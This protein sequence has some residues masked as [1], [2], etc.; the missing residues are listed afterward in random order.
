[1][2]KIPYGISNFES[3]ITEGYLYVDKTRFIRQI[4]EMAKFVFFVRPRRF[5]KS[6]FISLLDNYYDL[7]KADCFERLF[8][9]LEIGRQPTELRNRYLVLRLDFAAIETG[10]GRDV[11]RQSFQQ[12]VALAFQHFY[13][14][15]ASQLG[16]C[17]IDLDSAPE[18][19]VGQALNA[20]RQS[21]QKIY[22]LIDEYDNFANDLLAR[23]ASKVYE[24]MVHATGFVRTF[25]KALKEGTTSAIDRIFVTGVAPVMLDDLT[26]GFNIAENFSLNRTVHDTFGFTEAEL[27][28]IIRKLALP[29]D[30]DGLIAEMAALYNGY[31]FHKAASGAL[32]NSDMA[33]YYLM[34]LQREQEPPEHLIDHNVRTDYGRVR[35]LALSNP[36]NAERIDEILAE[37]RLQEVLV[38]QFSFDRMYDAEYFVSLLFY[39][40]LLSIDEERRG[41]LWLR[42]PNYAIHTLYWE[43]FRSLLHD[44]HDLR[45][46]ESEL[47]N[48]VEGLAWEGEVE[49]FAQYVAEHVLQKLSRRDFR[50][51]DEKHIK[52]ILF[53]L[54]GL[55][56][57]YLCHSER[58]VEH[59][60]IDLFLTRNARFPELPF[61][62]LIE[63][64]YLKE[65]E[66]DQL[67][68]VKD[69][70]R[71]QLQRYA[72]SPE[73]RQ[74]F[75]GEAIRQAALIF[76]GKGDV[77][78]V[79]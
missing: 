76:I 44:R 16:G 18:V 63:L 6:L 19:L 3:L 22:V 10:Q 8:G 53:A 67:D 65:G 49:P 62:W 46:R 37:E 61:E 17:T 43:Y 56:D 41:R 71:G 74:R 69:E 25:Y 48:A 68:A 50:H 40:G 1:M 57:F 30:E 29:M 45:I 42:I 33:L 58:E 78:I 72:S 9:S 60:F 75:R 27:R 55:T 54:L 39:L 77:E 36:A 12:K 11:L 7:A 47:G 15:Y 26:S 31:R 79:T 51:F 2:L 64:K 73:V 5:G 34:A 20:V 24:E 59:G 13:Q 35:S 28:D 38:P 21:G 4:E 23:G 14:R 32:Y 70:A 52:V 66:R